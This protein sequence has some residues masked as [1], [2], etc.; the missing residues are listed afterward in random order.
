M[1]AVGKRCRNAVSTGR[2]WTISPRALGL[3]MTM[4]RGSKSSMRRLPSPSLRGILTK[5]QAENEHQT[6][7]R[8]AEQVGQDVR[9]RGKEQC[10]GNERTE[11]ARQGRRRL[12]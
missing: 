12:I 2:L 6:Q 7:E 9:R 1:C 10:H 4:R 8:S 11:D 3:M 5:A